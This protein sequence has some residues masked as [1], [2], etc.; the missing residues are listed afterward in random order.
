MVRNFV[1][2]WLMTCINIG[3][4]FWTVEY[5]RGYTASVCRAAA[6]KALDELT[7]KR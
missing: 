6:I 4:I 7:G 3:S 2:L 5:Q 1:A